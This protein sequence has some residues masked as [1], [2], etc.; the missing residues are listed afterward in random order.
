MN[1]ILG[2][3]LSAGLSDEQSFWLL[4]SIVAAVPLFNSKTIDGHEAE[5]EVHR[6][7]RSGM[8]RVCVGGRGG[9]RVEWSG[10]EWNGVEYVPGIMRWAFGGLRVESSVGAVRGGHRVECSGVESSVCGEWESVHVGGV[11]MAVSCLVDNHQHATPKTL[12][13]G[14]HFVTD[15]L[16]HSR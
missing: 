14:A 10:V 13:R 16:T 9:H 8:E 5:Y 6:W 2:T 7:E 4:S 11:V 3:C 1:F 15:A 12:A